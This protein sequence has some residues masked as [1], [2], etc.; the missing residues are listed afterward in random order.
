MLST[1]AWTTMIAPGVDMPW[2]SLG[3]CCGSDPRVGVAPWLAAAT[4]QPI[5][6]ID[7]ALDYNDQGAIATELAAASTPRAK[8]F[9]TTKIPGAAHLNGDP[10]IDCPSLDYRACAVHA[11]KTDLAQLKM[12]AADLVLLHDPGLANGTAVTAALWQGMQDMLAAGLAR[13]IGVSNFNSMQVCFVT[14]LAC[15]WRVHGACMACACVRRGVRRGVRRAALCVGV[16][17]QLAVGQPACDA[18]CSVLAASQRTGFEIA[19]SMMAATRVAASISA[20]LSTTKRNS[21][22]MLEKPGARIL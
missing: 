5:A 12:A 16:A 11:V 8:V 20:E 9:L 19:M 22:R 17:V 2:V 21:S 6:G 7:T 1:R 13:S 15:A 4:L 14:A 10:K 3:T 18:R